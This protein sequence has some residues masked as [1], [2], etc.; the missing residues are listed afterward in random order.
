MQG[1]K[2]DVGSR[3]VAIA[4]VLLL[5]GYDV[6]SP[7]SGVSGSLLRDD[8]GDAQGAVPLHGGKHDVR[9]CHSG[10]GYYFAR[11]G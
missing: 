3:L 5:T 7:Q 9:S 4:A 11:A 10:N 8:S 6:V 2:L 1:G